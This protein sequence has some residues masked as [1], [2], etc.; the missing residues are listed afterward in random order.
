MEVAQ[1]R[2]LVHVGAVAGARHLE[3]GAQRL[4]RRLG[5]E[6]TEALA[7]LALE[8]VRVPIAVRAERGRAVV[9]VERAE[10][11]EPDRLGDLIDEP[12]E[13][14]GIGDVVP[15]RVEVAG[16]EADP[17][18][19]M[20]VE[21]VEQAGE[22]GDRASDRGARPGAV[23]HQEPGVRARPLEDP[24]E[25]GCRPVEPGVQSGAEVGADVEYD[26]V[27]I[28]C[29]GGV[30]GCR[31]RC[32]GSLV[33]LLVG[34]REV[35]EVKGVADEPADA[36]LRAAG[37]QS[38]DRG[39]GMVG[40]PPH[41]RTLREDLDALAADRLDPVDRGIDPSRRR[42]MAAELH[43][44]SLPATASPGRGARRRPGRRAAGRGERGAPGPAIGADA[45][46]RTTA[47]DAA[48]SVRVRMAPSPTG[49]LHV[50]GVRTFLFNWLFA[51]GAG[52][53]CRLRIENTDTGREVADAVDQIQRSLLWLGIYWD[54]PVTFQLDRQDEVRQ[55]AERL[56]VDGRAYTDEGA[57]RF[58]MPDEGVVAWEDAVR[59]R[60]EFQN[61]NLTDLVLV[62]S[63][64]R[65]TYNFASPV[66]DM[67]DG[68]THVIRGNDHVS[69]TPTQIN[70]LQ[71]LGAELPVYAHV[72]D[73]LGDD[74]KKLSKRHGAVSIDAFRA[75]GYLPAALMNFLALLGWS[76]DDKTTVM[77]PDELIERFRLDRV[78][79]SP[80]TFDYE[81]LDWL[82]GVHLRELSPEAYADALGAWLVEQG[83]GW[84]PE[85]VRRSAPLV[86]E[87]I[88]RFS[89]Y[90]DF[91]RFLFE[92]VHPVGADP[93]ICAAA[94]TVLERVEPWEAGP[95][96]ATLRALAAELGQKPRQAFQP[97]RVAITGSTVSPG[98][99][100]SL[101]LLGRDEALARL[102]AASGG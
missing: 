2:D 1:L 45:R 29:L 44:L 75:E 32:D 70:V 47:Y 92:P 57:I 51:R 48:V 19:R 58:R 72:P 26:G 77:S 102:A 98:L 97:I 28:E 14:D 49:F 73:V 61:A 90:P 52:G 86:Q 3:V 40:L 34:R 78:G 55:Q 53:E 46:T 23:L 80:A 54:G 62:R 81:K 24:R 25:G 68:I 36:R 30:H 50:G 83:I 7:D 12:A 59:G 16:V 6:D 22:L 79:P 64:G 63:D 9:D 15:A 39:G 82:N 65:P 4:E 18:P 31:E 20:A 67:L 43:P 89:Q 85:L 11:I 101:E 56:L 8:D 88:E 21:H 96:E 84:P 93:D 41:A 100:E 38:L 66:E 87:K 17:E 74:G 27:G 37:L 71:A 13:H 69:N 95:I 91:V 76:Y 94:A 99:F 42:D 35:A 60:I 5:Q 33:D 10:A